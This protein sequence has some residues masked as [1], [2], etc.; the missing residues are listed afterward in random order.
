MIDDEFHIFVE[1]LHKQFPHKRILPFEFKGQYYWLKQIEQLQGKDKWSKG[2]PKKAFERE[3]DKL[4]FMNKMQAPVPQLILETPTYFVL[5][6]TGIRLDHVLK[7]ASPTKYSEILQLAGK[8]LANL[9]QKDLIHGRP[10]LRDMT[11]LNGKISFIDFE[12]PLFS[13]HLEWQKVRDLFLLLQNLFKKQIDKKEIERVLQTYRQ[14]DGEIIYQ[15]LYLFIYKTRGLFYLIRCFKPI[16]GGD[17][18]AV[19]H[20]Y[21]FILGIHNEKI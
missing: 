9:H 18:L 5:Q 6:D 14:E 1:M 12:A 17:L 3:R 16:A 7:E 10:A 4:H 11:Y 21:S 15:M 8:T 19:I 20:L 13:R 2:N